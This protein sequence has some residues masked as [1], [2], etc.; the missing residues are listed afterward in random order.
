MLITMMNHIYVVSFVLIWWISFLFYPMWYI[1]DA[2]S[3]RLGFAAGLMVVGVVFGYAFRSLPN[4]EQ[5]TE[6][7]Q[8]ND[9]YFWGI[10]Y[11]GVF[12][13]HIPFL[14]LPV[15]TGLDM[16]DHASV[17][18]LV[19]S[20]LLSP[21][22]ARLGFPVSYIFT[23]LVIL[24]FVLFAGV[25]AVRETVLGK[26]NTFSQYFGK[27]LWLLYSI[28]IGFTIIYCGVI[29]FKQIPDRFGDIETLFRYQP[30]SKIMLIPAY[31]IFGIH[32][33]VGRVIQIG[34]FFAGAYFLYHTAFMFASK[35]AARLTAIL[36]L[37]LP[38]YS[39]MVTPISSK[40]AVCFLWRYRSFIGYVILSGAVQAISCW[41]HIGQAWG[42]YT[43]TPM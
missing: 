43:N 36:Y 42:V 18:A 39:I 29:Y 7:P 11:A 30:I 21:L 38:L 28:L 10:L 17:P 41:V 12:C 6:K 32:E 22:S 14:Q 13:L 25:K 3:T 16:I 33:W 20:K 5:G 9:L 27:R 26:I 4:S 2:G 19:A 31:L 40:A 35:D 34:F 1:P 37:L 24:F 15:I 8:Q 23:T